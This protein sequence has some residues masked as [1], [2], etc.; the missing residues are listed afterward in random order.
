MST[1]FE[2]WKASLT[3]RQWWHHKASRAARRLEDRIDTK[4]DFPKWNNYTQEITQRPLCFFLGHE[5]ISDQCGMP[6]HD[7]CA[8]CTKSTPNKAERNV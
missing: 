2:V 8:Y 3:R 7:F 5:A 6:E 4:F 1:A